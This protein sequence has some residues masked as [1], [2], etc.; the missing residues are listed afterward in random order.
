M[1][2]K[3][4]GVKSVDFKDKES[5]EQIRGLK[6]FVAYPVQDVKGRECDSKFIRNEEV[7]TI[8]PYQFIDKDIE[9]EIDMKGRIL[10]VTA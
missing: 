7:L 2:V 5:G 1:K 3:L 6:L 10:A 9:M 8:D 4:L